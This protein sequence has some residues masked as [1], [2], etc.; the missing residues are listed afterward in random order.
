LILNLGRSVKLCR[1]HRGLSQG[2]LAKQA[3]IS[4]SYLS[5]IEQNK[6]DPALSTI[7]KIAAGLKVPTSILAFLGAEPGEL[8]GLPMELQE[9]LSMAALGL[10]NAKAKRS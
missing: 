6:R 10:I 1:V 8:K 4:V 7:E 2:A 9:K 3:G 5:L